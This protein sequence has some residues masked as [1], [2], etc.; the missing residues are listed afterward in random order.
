M[1]IALRNMSNAMAAV[2]QWGG[3]LDVRVVMH[4]R[5]LAWFTSPSDRQRTALD[6]LRTRGVKFLVCNNTL[7]ESGID[8]HSLCGV[9]D[10]N[11]VPSG[12][13]EVALL[14]ISKGFVVDPAM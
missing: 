5:G 13:A 7:E 4:A 8:F 9:S 6:M 1:Q 12:F 14:Q 3:K 2:N 10:A 11:I